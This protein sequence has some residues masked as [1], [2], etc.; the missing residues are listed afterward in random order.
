MNNFIEGIEAYEKRIRRFNR[1]PIGC[2]LSRTLI[3]TYDDAI[4]YMYRTD[5]IA[6]DEAIS[7]DTPFTYTDIWHR[8]FKLTK[9]NE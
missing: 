5:I 3:I 2:S 4:N 8:E 9:V 1:A 7:K 6:F